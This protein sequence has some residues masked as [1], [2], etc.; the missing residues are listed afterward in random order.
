MLKIRN[1]VFLFLLGIS[2]MQ[3][4]MANSS[5][6][7]LTF[8]TDTATTVYNLEVAGNSNFYVSIGRVLVHNCEEGLIRIVGHFFECILN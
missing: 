8:R 1:V 4:M 6:S 3:M 2:A 5:E 7:I